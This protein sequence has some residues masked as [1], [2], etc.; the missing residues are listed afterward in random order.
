VEEAVAA[1]TELG[2]PCVV[3]P[4]TEAASIGV[5]LCRTAEEVRR[6]FTL[7]DERRTDFRGLAR[8]DGVLI[9]DYLIGYEL[10]VESVTYEGTRHLV[11]LT[12]KALGGHP[13]FVEVG[14]TFPSLLP[15]HVQKECVELAFAA[16][17]AVG[18]DFGA[19]HVEVKVTPDGPRLIEINAR[20]GGAQIGRIIQEST[21]LDLQRQVVRMH[22]GL[23]PELG[24]GRDEG[25]ASRYLTSSV[26]GTVAAIHGVELATRVPGVLEVELYVAPGDRLQPAE[27]NADVLGHLVVRAETSVQAARWADTALLQL[28]VDVHPETAQTEQTAETP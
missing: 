25:A 23:R 17:D 27:S 2:F 22:A 3:K 5:R 4:M 16:L 14:E 24:Q 11:G 7:L 1:A 19:S 18:H 12:D 28:S 20:M 10:S 8:P 21:G 15:A 26:R 9:E 6:H 13:H